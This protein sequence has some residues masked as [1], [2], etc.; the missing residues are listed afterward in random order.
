MT[1]PLVDKLMAVHKENFGMA[2]KKIK[3]HQRRYKSNYDRK[4]KVKKFNLKLGQ[5]VQYRRSDTKS[6]LSKT[7]RIV[8]WCPVSSYLVICEIDTKKR[9]VKLMKPDG[10]V[11]RRRQCFDNI[12]KTNFKSP[13]K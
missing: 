11:L 8:S 6:V 4:H 7:K 10:T 1:Q 2:S 13:N 5:H 12:R 3:K 9:Q